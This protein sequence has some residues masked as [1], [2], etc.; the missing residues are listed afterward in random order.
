MRR[1]RFLCLL[2]GAALAAPAF[3]GASPQRRFQWTTRSAEAKKLLA[4]LQ[5]R[6]ESFQFG[7]ANVEL[8]QKLVAAD[9]NFA[10]GMYYMSAVAAPPEEGVKY[11]EKSRELAKKASEGERRFIEAMVHSRLNQGVDFRKSIPPLE[12]LAED[13]P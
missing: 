4:E 2:M 11:Y 5:G 1:A 13:Y 10:M 12:A 3:A 8:A 7:P 6:I 9:P